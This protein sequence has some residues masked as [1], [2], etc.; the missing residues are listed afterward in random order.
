[1]GG[2]GILAGMGEGGLDAEAGVSGGWRLIVGGVV[3]R[4][5]V[6]TAGVGRMAV[7]GGTRP[8]M[9]SR[10]RCR[11]TGRCSGWNE[12]RRGDARG[13]S[14]PGWTR[15]VGGVDSV[16]GEGVGRRDTSLA[17]HASLPLPRSTA[18]PLACGVLMRWLLLLRTDLRTASRCSADLET[19]SWSSERRCWDGAGATGRELGELVSSRISAADSFCMPSGLCGFLTAVLLRLRGLAGSSAVSPASSRGGTTSSSGVRSDSDDVDD[20]ERPLLEL[21]LR[22]E[23]SSDER[24]SSWARMGI[25][26]RPLG[27][28]GVVIPFAAAAGGWL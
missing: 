16:L 2:S 13:C 15:V 21:V 12:Y 23:S 27:V 6:T 10:L 19:A 26:Q 14:S 7:A 3:L 4:A 5:G 20:S 17:F 22:C 1:M 18:L 9:P 28:G 25:G 11:G 8:L 24:S